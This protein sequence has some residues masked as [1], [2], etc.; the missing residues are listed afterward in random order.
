LVRE[1]YREEHAAIS[2]LGEIVGVPIP[3]LETWTSVEEE[4]ARGEK[5]LYWECLDFDNVGDFGICGREITVDYPESGVSEETKYVFFRAL[6]RTE[7][8][9]LTV[10]W[11]EGRGDV[12]V[13]QQP[14]AENSYT[15]CIRVD[16]S[17]YRRGDAY[18][19]EVYVVSER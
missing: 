12:T 13:I 15:A 1:A 19:F 16:D 3:P 11:L 6:P 18:K 4:I 9:H 7:G 8:V 10:K 17:R 14:N 2:L 5:L